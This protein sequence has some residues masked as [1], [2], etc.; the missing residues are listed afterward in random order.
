MGEP[1]QDWE[2]CLAD[3]TQIAD[4]ENSELDKFMGGGYAK[5][6]NWYWV[7]LVKRVWGKSD[8]ISSS[9]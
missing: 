7:K 8:H 6:D 9:S 3:P 2:I 5:K 1:S 4:P